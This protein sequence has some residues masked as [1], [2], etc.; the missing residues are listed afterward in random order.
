MGFDLASLNPITGI[1]GKVLDRVLP[2]KEKQLEAQNEMAKMIVSGEF[3]QIASQ[4]EVNKA[5]AMSGKIFVAGWRPF[6]GWICGVAIAMNFIIAP[7]AEFG[8]R[9]HGTPV[10]FPR[11]D[12]GPLW[13]LLATM[14]GVG[15]MRTVEKVQGVQDNH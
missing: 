7:F 14:L 11:I 6:I 5:E 2:D 12:L 13:A 8:S 9:L 15:V 4:L 10:E 1:V 3:A